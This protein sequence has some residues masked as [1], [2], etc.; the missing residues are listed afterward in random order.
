[1]S[2]LGK[3]AA[4]ENVRVSAAI[5]TLGLLLGAAP[6]A[7]APIETGRQTADVNGAPMVV[8][9]WVSASAIVAALKV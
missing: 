7:A 9:T 2:L 6:L 1:V 5:A 8:F 4:P 3:A